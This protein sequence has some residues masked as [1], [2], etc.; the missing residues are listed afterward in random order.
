MGKILPGKHY[1][2]MVFEFGTLDTQTTMGSIKALHNVI[3]ENQGI[4]I[5]Y[6]SASD[7]EKVKSRF[8]QGYYP[9]SRAWRS[10]AIEDARQILSQAV[11]KYQHTT[12]EETTR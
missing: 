3:I 1:L 7:E 9:S 10:K 12:I 2:T 8:L 11:K 4:Q 6:K 5:G